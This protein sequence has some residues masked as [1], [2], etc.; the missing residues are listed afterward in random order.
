MLPR[1]LRYSFTALCGLGFAMLGTA[2]FAQA[3]PQHNIVLSCTPS[4]TAGVQYNFYRSTVSGGPYTKQNTAP[5]A[6]CSF[7]DTSLTP[8]TVYFYVATAVDSGGFESVFSNQSSAT[9]K[10]NPASPTGLTATAN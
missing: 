2:A 7:A 1:M 4:A 5:L 6:G 3:A 8:G 9:A 10:V